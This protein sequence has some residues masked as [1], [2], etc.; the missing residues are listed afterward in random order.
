ML[1]FG[2][3]SMGLK[4]KIHTAVRRN[5]KEILEVKIFL[6]MS[7]GFKCRGPDT[8]EIYYN[9]GQKIWV[10]PIAYGEGGGF[11]ARAIKLAA[12]TLEPFHPE[13][14]KFLTSL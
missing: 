6:K 5:I 3:I 4:N 13:S 12:R 11:L 10:N 2:N 9:I 1:S 8:R 7:L 14:P